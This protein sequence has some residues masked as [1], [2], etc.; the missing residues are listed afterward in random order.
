MISVLVDDL[1]IMGASEDQ[2][3]I[4]H[5]K[6]SKVYK[7]SQFEKVKVYNGIHIERTGKHV[8]LLSQEYSISQFL[9]RCP[10]KDIN[11]CDSPL[12][13]LVPSDTFVLATEKDEGLCTA[14]ERQQLL[15]SLNWFNIATRP[16]LAIACS[17]AG[18]VASNPTKL[19]LKQ[20][21]RVIGYLKRNLRKSSYTTEANAMVR[22]G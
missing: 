9:A 3:M 11:P 6:F 10:V 16:D 2:V 17:L 13:P 18:R 15:G 21:R 12:V 20:L 14:R 1:L 7:V 4:F 19:Q 22:L 5:E 8:Y